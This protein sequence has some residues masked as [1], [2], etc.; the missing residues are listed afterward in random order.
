MSDLS[1][2]DSLERL[3]KRSIFPSLT[4]AGSVLGLRGGDIGVMTYTSAADKMKVFSAFV[5]EGLESG[6]MVDYTY[7]DEE[8]DTVRARL[9]KYGVD[10][11]KY[12]RNGG[13][14]LRSLTE[15]HLSE[16]GFDKER[17]IDKELDRRLEAKSRGYKHYRDIEDL[18]GFSFLNGQWKKYMEYWDSPRWE[19]S[20]SPYADVLSRTSFVIELVA[21]NVEGLTEVELNEILK[22]FRRGGARDIVFIDLLEYKDAFSRLL[23]TPHQ[24]IVGGKFLLEFDPASNYETVVDD[25]AKECVAN[26]EPIFVFTFR[27]SPIH[28]HLAKQSATKFFLTSVSTSTPKS[29]SENEVLLPTMRVHLI[30]DAVDKTL[31]IHNDR[32]ICFVFDIL[33]E[34]LTLIGREKTFSFLSHALDMLSSSKITCLFLLNSSA[35]EPQVVSQIRNLFHNLLE[36]E[37]NGLKVVKIFRQSSTIDLT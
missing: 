4:Q 23:R 6:D 15:H 11:E 29:I 35:H 24:R 10:V 3:W 33:S 2:V 34:L 31:R 16:A 37:K 18:S 9:K 14:I 32:N 36:Y 27:T 30:L 28:K 13:L 26:V 8:S 21:L 17:A 20:S 19:T 7:P 5:R 22:A 1:L 25:F 12:E